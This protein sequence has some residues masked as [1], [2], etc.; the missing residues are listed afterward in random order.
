MLNLFNEIAKTNS[1]REKIELLRAYPGQSELKTVLLLATDPFI[2][3]GITDFEDSDEFESEPVYGLLEKLSRRV[4][5]GGEA[6]KRLGASIEGEEAEV[7]RRIL[8]KDLRCGVGEKLV[9]SLYPGLIRQF[10]IMRAVKFDK[11]NPRKH[12]VIEPKIDGLRCVAFVEGQSVTLLSRNG[13]EFTSSD[14]LK[15]EILRLANGQDLVFDGELTSGNFNESASAIKKKFSPNENTIFT[16]FDV[17]DKDDWKS[18]ARIYHH[19]RDL[20]IRLFESRDFKKLKITS[21][22]PVQSE[23]EV[24]RVYGSFLANG[25]EGGMVK[26]TSGLYRQRKHRDWMKL[27]EVNE[28]DMVCEGLIQGEGKY[29]GMV[30]AL[31]FKFKGKR[32]TVGTGFSDEERKLWWE[33]PELIKGK[34]CEIHYHQVTP[35][36]NLRHSRLHCIRHDK[37]RGD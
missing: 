23:E 6:R 12:Y 8:R 24:F 2:K 16:I 25:Y 3:F 14:H 21:S 36:G 29:H 10:N 26:D 30:G 22:I 5:A 9:L 27:K 13:L 4:Y 37:D 33:R 35:D 11:L 32:N 7:I 31:V 18:P 17:L 1:P 15:P 19:R 28:V 34:V 20:L